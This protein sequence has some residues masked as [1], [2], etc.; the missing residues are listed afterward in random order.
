MLF[1]SSVIGAKGKDD[2]EGIIE[3]G[4]GRDLLKE[5]KPFFI[6]YDTVSL[7]HR[8]ILELKV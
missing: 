1:A 3:E 6:G 2:L 4:T 5:Q 8:E 7:R